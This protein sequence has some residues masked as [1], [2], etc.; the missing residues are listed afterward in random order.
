M[1]PALKG[2]RLAALFMLGVL[3]IAVIAIGMRFF[4]RRWPLEKGGPDYRLVGV[5]RVYTVLNKLGVIPLGIFAI[6]YP[7]TTELEVLMRGWGY[8]P[9]RLETVLP[10]LRDQWGNPSSAYRF[11]REVA[12]HIDHARAH[13]LDRRLDIDLVRRQVARDLIGEE[14]ADLAQQLAEHRRGRV[15]VAHQGELVEDERMIDHDERLGQFGLGHGVSPHRKRLRFAEC[16]PH[17]QAQ[18]ELIHGF[19]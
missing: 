10:F 1:Q 6:T 9:P 15:L 14:K 2:P 7:V 12:K 17:F 18:P 11:G 3:Q 4:E 5:D 16:A 19:A 8:A 13:R